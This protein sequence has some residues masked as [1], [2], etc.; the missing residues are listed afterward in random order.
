MTATV[1]EPLRRKIVWNPSAGDIHQQERGAPWRVDVDEKLRAANAK[2][3][4]EQL[5]KRRWGL[6]K[7]IQDGLLHTYDK[8][9]GVAELATLLKEGMALKSRQQQQQQQEKTQRD[10]HEVAYVQLLA[11]A[12]KYD[13]KQV[14]VLL[15]KFPKGRHANAAKPH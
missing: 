13:L 4:E 14:V 8:N 2:A 9:Y 3:K 7:Q 10:P 1:W 12:E 5:E 11:A 6:A 15:D